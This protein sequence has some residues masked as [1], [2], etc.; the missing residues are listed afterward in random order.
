MQ[1][2]VNNLIFQQDDK[3]I[4][5]ENLGLFLVSKNENFSCISIQ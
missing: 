3:V 1:L 5:K 2:I 4:Q